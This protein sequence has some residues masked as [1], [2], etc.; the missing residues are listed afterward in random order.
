MCELYMYTHDCRLLH[1]TSILSIQTAQT[2]TLDK[3]TCDQ[4]GELY[5]VGSHAFLGISRA[6]CP[7]YPAR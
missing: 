7:R 2:S 5:N 6:K 3:I 4:T 1:C